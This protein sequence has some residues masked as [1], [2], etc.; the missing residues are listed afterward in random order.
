MIA[1]V[2]FFKFSFSLT[3]IEIVYTLKKIEEKEK[4]NS[5][6]SKEKTELEEKEKEKNYVLN[7][8]NS[9]KTKLDIL[10]ELEKEKEG[11]SY[12]VK[13]ILE[14]KEKNTYFGKKVDNILANVIST[15]EKYILA[16]E[17]ALRIYNAKYNC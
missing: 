12:S 10:K 17:T 8:L 16:L 11:L 1:R 14:E 15:D 5:K 13:K 6:F 3:Y 9:L 2:K 4:E 7:N